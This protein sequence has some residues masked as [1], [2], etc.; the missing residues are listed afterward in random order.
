MEVFGISRQTL[1]RWKTG[2]AV[3]KAAMRGIVY[4]ELFRRMSGKQLREFVEN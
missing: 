4:K 3:P 2:Q 1:Q